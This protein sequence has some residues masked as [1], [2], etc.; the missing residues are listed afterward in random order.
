MQID[1]RKTLRNVSLPLQIERKYYM[2]KYLNIGIMNGRVCEIDG[3]LHNRNKTF[4]LSE[5]KRTFAFKYYYDCADGCFLI[6]GKVSEQNRLLKILSSSP[7]EM[8]C[9]DFF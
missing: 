5:L 1:N 4:K 2:K 8:F 9:F 6:L 3:K 7:T